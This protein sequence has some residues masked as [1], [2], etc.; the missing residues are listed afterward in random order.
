MLNN[1]TKLFFLMLSGFSRS[2]LQ[3]GR[4]KVYQKKIASCIHQKQCFRRKNKVHTLTKALIL[5]EV[6]KTEHDFLASLWVLVFFLMIALTIKVHE[7][8]CL[9]NFFLMSLQGE[10]LEKKSCVRNKGKVDNSKTSTG[11]CPVLSMFFFFWFLFL[12][13]VRPYFLAVILNN[14]FLRLIFGW[15]FLDWICFQM[16]SIWMF[17]ACIEI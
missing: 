9:D 10:R 13:T 1:C 3:N 7:V 16:N 17:K 2:L 11:S 12:Q 4:V 15:L 14:F 5:K 8:C 6:K